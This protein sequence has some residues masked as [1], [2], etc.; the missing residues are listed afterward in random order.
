[1]GAR[2]GHEFLEGLRDGREVWLG[3]KRVDVAEHPAFAGSRAGLAG[4]F[5]WQHQHADRCLMKDAQS[6]EQIGVSHLIPRSRD[7]LRRRAVALECLARYSAGAL[8]RTPDYVNVTTAGFAGR[9]D[10]FGKNGNTRAVAALQNFQREVA[11]KDLALTHTIVHPVVDKSVDDI[12]GL[13]GELALKIVKRTDRGIVV[14]GA[15]VLATLGPFAD[16]LFVYPGQPLPKHADAAY[17]L[18]FSVPMATKGLITICRDHY[19]TPGAA[20]DR[21][22]SSR[23]DE[24][25]A[26]IVFDDVE[27]PWDRV[28]IDGDIEIYNKIMGSGWTGN[29]M[30]QTSI[31]AA[32]K[33]E[34]AYE[35]ATRM[36]EAQN[37]AGR[38]DN[39]QM[40]GEIWC[41]S[42]QV[43][44]SLRAAEADAHEYGAGTWFC[45]DRP[46]RA[47]RSLVPGWMARTNEILKLLG[48]HNLLATPE[49]AAFEQPELRA[50]LER[51]LPGSRGM[52]AQE[53]AQLFRTAWDF[54]GSALGSR[55]ELYERFYLASV[56]RTLG[57]NHMLAQREQA[58]NAVPEFIQRSKS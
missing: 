27:V 30:Q 21:P 13:N 54:V 15:R 17:A 25:D 14:R 4:Y 53:R 39:Q 24:Q 29:V 42:A 22:F 55:N 43:R 35:L 31:R 2:R 38:T 36:V 28:F 44:A 48:A 58:W 50:T 37:A 12:S 32:V 1:M 20:V 3:S 51:Y 47:L 6:G 23:F 41:Y 16:E 56:A 18:A 9:P 19:G 45:D 40:L 46:Y 33:L 5:D 52:A 57:L 11:L 8:G 7:D 49:A 10:V 26:F 34:F